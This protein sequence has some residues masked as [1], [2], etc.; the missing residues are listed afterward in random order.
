MQILRDPAAAALIT[1][2]DIRALVE[3]RFTQ[4]IDD[5]PYDPE[6]CG[7]MIVVEVGDT[8]AALEQESGCPIL[9]NFVD[10]TRF[11]DPGYVPSS[12]YLDEHASCYEMAFIHGVDIF[13]PKVAGIDAEL[14]AMCAQFSTPAPESQLVPQ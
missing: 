1:D 2:P 9:G 7:Y 4:L 12:E 13:I 14:L 8:V 5:E 3:L 11:R 6:V 10:A